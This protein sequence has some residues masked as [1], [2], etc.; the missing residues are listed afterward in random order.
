MPPSFD[1]AA[2]RRDDPAFQAGLRERPTTRLV[3][4]W[5]SRSLVTDASPRRA[6]LPTVADAPQLLAAAE[7]VVFRGLGPG[8]TGHLLVDLPRDEEPT[9]LGAVFQDLRLV[10]EALPDDEFAL[11]AYARG[12]AHWHRNARFDPKTG[13]PTVALEGG[14]ARAVG[15]DRQRKVFPR[16][17]PAVMVLVT[18]GEDRCL[19]ARQHGWPPGMHSALAGFVEPGENLEECVR[20]ETEEEVGLRVDQLDYRRS[21]AW[22]F[23]RSLMIGF[24]AVATAPEQPLRLDPTEIEAARWVTRDELRE[25]T[26]FFIPPRISLAFHLIAEFLDEARN[27]S[28]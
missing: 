27:V 19:L 3:P 11:L 18:D 5:R 4:V 10:G 24:R 12:M 8:E 9:A 25:P 20:R 23:P 28:G 13:A 16:T 22:P 26:D 1:R 7:E 6:V 21:Q 15:G 14:F 17:D 2:L